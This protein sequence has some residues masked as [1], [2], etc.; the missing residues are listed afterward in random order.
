MLLAGGK[1][2][3]GK[4]KLLE[5]SATGTGKT[6]LLEIRIRKTD[7]HEDD[8]GY[9]AEKWL[10]AQFRIKNAEPGEKHDVYLWVAEDGYGPL[11][12]LP[13]FAAGIPKE[14]E[15]TEAVGP[16]WHDFRMML[17]GRSIH[18]DRTLLKGWTDQ[19]PPKNL[20]RAT[21]AHVEAKF[22][23]LE[24]KLRF[25]DSEN[26]PIDP[27]TQALNVSNWVTSIGLP[28][29]SAFD[30][31]CK[32]EKGY[33][34]P[35]NF[36]I[37]VEDGAVTGDEV[38]VKLDVSRK[39]PAEPKGPVHPLPKLEYTLRRK[40]GSSMFRGQWLRLVSDRED[41]SVQA[42]QT[43][44]VEL[45]DSVTV[46]YAPDG[47]KAHTATLGV[48]RASKEDSNGNDQKRHDIRHLRLH[49]VVF[50]KPDGSGPVV[51][52]RHVEQDIVVLNETLA[53]ATIHVRTQDV[54][55]DMGHGDAGVVL[56]AG[57]GLNWTDGFTGTAHDLQWLP[58]RPAFP[59]VMG[60]PITPEEI[61][62]FRFADEDPD[63]VDVFY[64]TRIVQLKAGSNPESQRGV[65]Y[66]AYRNKTGWPAASGNIVL[67]YDRDPHDPEKDKAKRLASKSILTFPHELMHILLDMPHRTVQKGDTIGGEGSRSLFMSSYYDDAKNR[68]SYYG[69]RRIGPFRGPKCDTFT[70]GI[71]GAR[72]TFT[73]RDNTE[74]LPRAKP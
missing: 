34:D 58:I 57:S 47:G 73:I 3:P 45:G 62:L 67:A 43:I 56:P 36:R 7:T 33:V 16:G 50:R 59:P 2:P 44:L 55:I 72:D 30:D 23:V 42:K 29:K 48:G 24:V 15:H 69:T 60:I 51:N 70:K 71:A 13:Y 32:D 27:N 4:A 20:C 49:V 54:K 18:R 31:T 65:S 39:R 6:P 9:L 63:T 22:T 74:R 53:Q 21:K 1:A 26:E 37:E 12:H 66:G 25:L 41:D 8:I 10:D 11:D 5:Q 46:S 38:R 28:A 17:V 64:V 52:R 68:S 40:P 61:A 35:D 14:H 19:A